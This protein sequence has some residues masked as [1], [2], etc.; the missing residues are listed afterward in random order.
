ML[1]S[2]NTPQ[3]PKL[4]SQDLTIAT[5]SP[6]IQNKKQKTD[7]KTPPSKDPTTPPIP[8]SVKTCH[9]YW[10]AQKRIT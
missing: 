8:A 6:L 3:Q 5:P 10:G 7:H 1:P 4:N 9:L 2:I